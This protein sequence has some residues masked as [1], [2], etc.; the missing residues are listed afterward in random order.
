MKVGRNDPCPCGSGQKYKKC[1]MEKDKEI[2]LQSANCED[3]IDEW[4]PEDEP[5][6]DG[7]NN[8]N[9]NVYD[10]DDFTSERIRELPELSDEESDLVDDWWAEY[11]TLNDTVKEREHL[12]AFMDR[13]PHLVD[14][15]ELYHEVLFELDADHFKSDN[16]EIFVE[17]MLRIRKEFLFTY[18]KTRGYYDKN[19]IYWYVLQG[20]LDEM[21]PFF[22][23][24]REDNR[25]DDHLDD[26]I[27]FFH[28]IDRADILLTSLTGNRDI[29]HVSFIIICNILQ[30]YIEK[31]VTDELVQSLLDEFVS[32]S[33][34]YKN[35]DTDSIKESLLNYM[36]PLMPW[37][38]ELPKK[39]SEA[40]EYYSAISLNF[41]YF[42]YKNT[43]L[44][45]CSATY[46][47][48]FIEN[49]Y[50]RIVNDENKRPVDVF[51][52]DKENILNH[53]LNYYDMVYWGYDMRCFIELSALYYYC[54]YLK[55]CGNIS[56]EQKNEL[57]EMITNF[58][59]ET[60][61]VSKEMGPEMLL[62]KQFPLWKMKTQTS[63]A[64]LV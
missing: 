10:E 47:S 52:L 25:Y 34:I 20:R 12:I 62:F 1:C 39:R 42:L 28:A 57:Q 17:L 31:P 6:Y 11:K 54:A 14:H 40:S 32:K 30:R 16:Y 45:F 23:C 24:F 58:Y 41:A 50:K 46:I 36:R 9:L 19:L 59:E 55:I 61:K 56:E 29:E 8:N 5:V 51:C 64:S 49:Y 21:D 13:Y 38:T 63:T 60:Y 4:E 15:L 3:D 26:L 2:A 27:Q 22:D 33:V 35:Y 7:W 37:D 44:S 53:T 43:D 48:K 18:K